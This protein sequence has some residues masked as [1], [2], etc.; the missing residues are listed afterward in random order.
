[1]D[2]NIL[3]MFMTG[4][5]MKIKEYILNKARSEEKDIISGYESYQKDIKAMLELLKNGMG[6]KNVY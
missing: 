6:E 5:S 2:D 3:A 1:M 4:A